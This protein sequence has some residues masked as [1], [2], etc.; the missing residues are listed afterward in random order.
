[1]I[2]YCL[3]LPLLPERIELAKK[4]AEE[5]GGHNKEHNEFYKTAGISRVVKTSGFSAVHQEVVL[6]I[7]R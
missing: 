1:M 4:F 3:A 7:L 6:L 2:N 5:N